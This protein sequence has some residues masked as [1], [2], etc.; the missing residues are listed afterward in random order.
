MRRENKPQAAKLTLDWIQ[1]HSPYPLDLL[2]HCALERKR[3][4]EAPDPDRLADFPL[5]YLG[6][7]NTIDDIFDFVRDEDK[8]NQLLGGG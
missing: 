6:D 2:L 7:L 8:R 5:G 4:G 1:F 3:T